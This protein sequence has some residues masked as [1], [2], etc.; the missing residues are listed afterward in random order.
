[1]MGMEE[2]AI[3]GRKN[4]NFCC[5]C[6]QGLGVLGVLQILAGYALLRTSFISHVGCACRWMGANDGG[7]G[8]TSHSKV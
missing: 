8:R 4:D 2:R 7:V 5:T 1:M 3:H 6:H